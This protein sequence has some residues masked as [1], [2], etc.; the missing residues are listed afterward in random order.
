MWV[1]AFLPSIHGPNESDCALLCAGRRCSGSCECSAF[2]P[3]HSF[4][5]PNGTDYA[6]AVR[7]G[8]GE[9]WLPRLFA[10]IPWPNGSPAKKQAP[11]L[12]QGGGVGIDNGQVTFTDSNI[13]GNWALWV[14]ARLSA[15]DPWARMDQPHKYSNRI[16]PRNMINMIVPVPSY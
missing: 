7:A 3:P 6:L 5:G 16:A 9:L 10:L 8:R 15:P 4:H 13:Y 11:S 1:V 14:S 2:C 12:L